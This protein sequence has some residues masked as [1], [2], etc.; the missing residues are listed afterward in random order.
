MNGSLSFPPAPYISLSLSSGC[1][2]SSFPTY[3]CPPPTLAS[4]FGIFPSTISFLSCM[5]HCPFLLLVRQ[6]EGWWAQC[7][8]LL[9]LSLPTSCLL[10]S[11]FS[12]RLCP[13]MHSN[14]EGKVYYGRALAPSSSSARM[15]SGIATFTSTWSPAPF[16]Y[17]SVPLLHPLFRLSHLVFLNS[18]I[19]SS[20]AFIP[21]P[22]E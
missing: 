19:K 16:P 3:Q 8:L 10:S 17:S 13:G 7:L 11:S 22:D 1:L 15:G 20:W 9:C 5:A 12:S 14:S 18:Q 2:L 21:S 4:Q 6:K